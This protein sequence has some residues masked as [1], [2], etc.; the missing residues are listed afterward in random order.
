MGNT[1]ARIANHNIEDDMITL[2]FAARLLL[3][4][5]DR[6]LIIERAFESMADFGASDRIGMFVFDQEGF[7]A[8]VGGLIDNGKEKRSF[9]I[10]ELASPW[11]QIFVTKNHAYLP[12]AY[13]EGIP[14]PVSSDGIEG[15]K[16]LCAPLVAANNQVVG[17]VTF[18]YASDFSMP[19]LM[20]QSLILLLTIVA[21]ALETARLF[22]QAIYDG[23]T[24]LYIRRYF[25]LRLTEEE[26][27]IRRYGGRMA[28]LMADI[29][30]F[31]RINDTY[32]HQ[33]GDQVL[34]E[35]A[36]IIKLS[37]RKDLDSPCRYGGEE[38]V[39]IMPDTDPAGALQFRNESGRT[40]RTT[41]FMHRAALS[42]LP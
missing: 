19:P 26:N 5:L 29:D 40:F 14:V 34:R 33:L 37:I 28:I 36:D 35:V 31:K 27:R 4:N 2:G 17:I 7:L 42:I 1:S 23:L 16:C 11:E 39:V 3:V 21:V 12:L 25:D 24:G 22:Q 38:F 20:M 30:H 10:D 15:G 13:Q 6:E 9:R 41:S 32:G 8:C 18:A